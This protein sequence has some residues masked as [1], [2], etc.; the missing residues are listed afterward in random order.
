VYIPAIKDASTE[1]SENKNTALGRLLARTVRAKINF[2]NQLQDI[3]QKAH[4]DYS[5]LL[6]QSQSALSGLSAT[7]Q[8]R[9]VNWAHPEA[10]LR[11]EWRQDLERAISVQEPA[12]HIVVGEDLFEGQLCRLGHGL[13]RSYL[14]ALLQELAVADD[15]SGP[16][17][18][19]ACEEPELFQHPPQAMHLS[20]VFESLAAGN[21]Q[22]LICTHSPYFVSG[23]TFENIRLIQK[24]SFS[25]AT[26]ASSVTFDAV[27]SEIARVTGDRPLKRSGLRAKMEQ[28]LQANLN[29]MFFA[30]RIVF[31]EGLEDSAFLVS[32]LTLSGRWD[33]FRR[34]GAHI[35]PVGGKDRLIQ[36]LTVAN[37]FGIPSITIFDSDGDEYGSIDLTKESAQKLAERRPMHIRDNTALLKLS[38][39]DQFDPFPSKTLFHG[40][41]VMWHSIADGRTLRHKWRRNLVNPVDWRRTYFK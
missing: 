16:T 20:D 35:I 37:A 22:V 41:L 6:S 26:G 1:Q 15:K 13:Q 30:R 21:T 23:Q 29:E 25:K 9:L 33:D 12:A 3:R 28:A 24:S 7:L 14:L 34:L 40:R 5:E 27:A 32:Y 19:L 4:Q 18:L 8:Q 10:T 2:S 36:P 11:L 39:I 31:V 38:G 17:L